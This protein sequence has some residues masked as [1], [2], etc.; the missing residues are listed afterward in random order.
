MFDINLYNPFFNYFLSL[1]LL[2][3]F[4]FYGIRVLFCNVL[5]CLLAM[6]T[7]GKVVPV[8]SFRAFRMGFFSERFLQRW[9]MFVTCLFAGN[10][11]L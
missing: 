8:S 6:F 5:I 4:T 3:E 11:L 10:M 2:F 9:R 1:R 7:T